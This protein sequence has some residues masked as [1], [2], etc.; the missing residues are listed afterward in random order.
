MY[1][2][3]IPIILQPG[4]SS[5]VETILRLYSIGWELLSSLLC[6]AWW[7]HNLVIIGNI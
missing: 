5:V 7:S 1:N 3:E 6:G 4:C 2:Y